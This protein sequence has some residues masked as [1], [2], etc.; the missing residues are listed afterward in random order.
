M[1]DRALLESTVAVESACL[2]AP[3][4]VAVADLRTALVLTVRLAAQRAI[5]G[6]VEITPSPTYPGAVDALIDASPDRA[7][8]ILKEHR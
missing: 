1:T 8:S 5:A 3:V 6:P 7:R 2:Q 4:D